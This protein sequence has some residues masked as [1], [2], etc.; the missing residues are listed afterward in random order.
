M[1]FIARSLELRAL[2]YAFNL[3]PRA[4]ASFNFPVERMAA[5]GTCLKTRTL[6]ARRHRSPLRW[7]TS[8]A[9]RKFCV[10][11]QAAVAVGCAPTSSK[12]QPNFDGGVL[13]DSAVLAIARAAVAKNDTWVA[14]AEFETPKRQS[15]G[16]WRVLVWRLPKTPGGHRFISID[17]NGR[18]TDYGRG[19]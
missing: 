6:V 15:D 7:A 5:G 18:V 4:A 2:P 19:L 1:F 13:D 10:I 17:Q 16:S 3:P 8:H 12:Q 14:Q 11:I 9:M